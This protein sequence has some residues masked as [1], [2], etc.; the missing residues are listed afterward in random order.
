MLVNWY[1]AEQWIWDNFIMLSCSL[2]EGVIYVV[3]AGLASRIPK[4]E[5]SS[6]LPQETEIRIRGK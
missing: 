2:L 6:V 5:M 4:A 3:L 1:N